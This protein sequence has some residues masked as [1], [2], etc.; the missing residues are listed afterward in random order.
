L[1]FGGGPSIY[2]IIFEE[3]GTQE[4]CQPD[5][6]EGVNGNN[7]QAN[8]S[9]LTIDETLDLTLCSGDIDFFSFYAERGQSIKVEALFNGDIA[10]LDL[11]IRG[12]SYQEETLNESWT[13]LSA[14]SNEEIEI[15]SAPTTGT[16]I[17]ETYLY[18]MDNSLPYQLRLTLGD[19]LM[20]APDRLEDNNDLSMAESLAFDLYT[21]LRACVDEDWYYTS[22]SSNRNLLIYLTY[23][24]GTPQ[25]YVE[26]GI[27]NPLSYNSS[28]IPRSDGCLAERALCQ[29]ISIPNMDAEQLIYYSIYFDQVGIGYDLRIRQGD[30]VSAT[31]QSD[32]DCNF[33]YECLSEFDYYLFNQ[34]MCAESCERS[35][36]CGS[37]RTC[38]L[39]EA[40]YGICVQLCDDVMQCRSPF[41]CDAS[42]TNAEQQEVAACISDEYIEF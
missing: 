6:L 7:D 3:I 40:N 13:A 29:R 10:D 11:K 12:P 41:I 21:D 23:D 31:C 32:N 25:I 30:E 14:T 5:D 1:L 2:E 15:E 34:G 4:S 38:I 18:E 8:A 33:G 36:D 35:A 26:D 42:I 20:C 17:V 27:G 37:G 16:Y 24:R 28:L 22:A 19:V 9:P 39:D